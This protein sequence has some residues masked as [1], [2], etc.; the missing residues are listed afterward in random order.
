MHPTPLVISGKVLHVNTTVSPLR[1]ACTAIY[2]LKANL[3]L[4]L[5]AVETNEM[6]V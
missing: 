2:A 6:G 4:K 1:S 3:T 5:Y